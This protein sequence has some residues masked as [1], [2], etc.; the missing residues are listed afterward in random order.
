M[1]CM[2]RLRDEQW[3]RILGHFPAEH[4]PESRPG[5]KPV[6]ARDVL[7]TVLWILNT[8][9]PW[10]ML[11]QCYPNYKTVHRRFQQWC[12]RAVLTSCALSNSHPSRCCSNDVAIGS[13]LLNP[14]RRLTGRS[15]TQPPGQRLSNCS[16]HPID[17]SNLQYGNNPG[18]C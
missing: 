14:L 12:V 2:L 7:D 11:P 16:T 1:R 18:I 17:L 13:T 4:I 3:G 9:A 5:H 15:L 10:H 8:G 6:P